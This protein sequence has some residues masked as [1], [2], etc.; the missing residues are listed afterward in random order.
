MSEGIESTSSTADVKNEIACDVDIAATSTETNATSNRT[1]LPENDTSITTTVASTTSGNERPPPT[2][3]AV[4]YSLSD[5]AR[6]APPSSTEI[7][8]T[9][10]P[11]HRSSSPQRKRFSVPETP[12]W[13]FITSAKKTEGYSS[14][15]AG[16]IVQGKLNDRDQ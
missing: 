12:R 3:D 5:T 9:T 14:V 4:A 10:S 8:P 7:T 6:S 11:E 16:T 1:N 13:R 2:E 15:S